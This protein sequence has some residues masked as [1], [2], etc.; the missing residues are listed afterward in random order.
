[1]VIPLKF[2][3]VIVGKNS[4]VDHFQLP[5]RFS[6]LN[7]EPSHQGRVKNGSRP[8]TDEAGGISG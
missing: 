4:P 2:E 3:A 6:P 1:M 8:Q 5:V 7:K